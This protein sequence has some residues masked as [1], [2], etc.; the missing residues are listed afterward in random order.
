MGNGVYGAW[1]GIVSMLKVGLHST[2]AKNAASL[3]VIQFA[4]YILPLITVPYLVR[5]LEPSGY[6]L[7]AFGQSLIAYFTIFAD[8][9]FAFSATRKISLHRDNILV[10]SSTASQVWA[11]KAVL[12]ALGFLILFAVVSYVP[13]LQEISPLVIILYGVVIGNVLFPT[14][15]FQGME[16]MVF[17]SVINLLMQFFIL[18]GVFKLV[19]SPD[20]VMIYTGIISIGSVLSGLAGAC[21][22]ILLFKL[23][24][25]IPSKKDV[26]ET[27]QEGW[28]L[29]FSTASVS[30]YTAG[31]AFI[32]GLLANATAVGYYSVAEK[33]AYAVLGL[34]SPI[35][36][37]AYPR[38]NKLA[39]HSKACALQWARR[40][41]LSVASLGLML[42]LILFIGAPIIVRLVL[43]PSYEPSI[44]VLRILAPLPFLVAISNVFGIQLMVPFGKDRVFAFILFGAGLVNLALA[45]ALSPLWDESGMALAVLI[46]EMFVAVVMFGYLSLKQL[47]PIYNIK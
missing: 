43:G 23:H 15:L 35:G 11:S 1:N 44:M 39:A 25:I 7:V 36:Q 21:M 30:L 18:I 8:Y 38:F 47:N 27:L 32:L 45:I 40:M 46:S 26:I 16:K 24:L 22:A 2:V 37:A 41:L 10:V 28:I 19:H 5:V 4:Q 33:I 9:G 13:K 34:L 12:G 20:D 31:N 3:Y 14:W 29:F 6:G 42:S 17:I